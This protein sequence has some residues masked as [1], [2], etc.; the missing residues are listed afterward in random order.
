MTKHTTTSKLWIGLSRRRIG[1]VYMLFAF[2]IAQAHDPSTQALLQKAGGLV[3]QG[4]Y[5][6]ASVL[7]TPIFSAPNNSIDELQL[8]EALLLKGRIGLTKVGPIE[9]P[10][11]LF[12]ESL[13][14]Y[15]RYQD[16]A[17]ISK[18]NLQLGVVNYDLKNYQDAITYLKN[19]IGYSR[20][21]DPRI[22]IAHYLLAICYSETHEYDEAEDM[23]DLAQRELGK[24]NK[25]FL[26]QIE[27][28]RA[29]MFINRG[30][31]DLALSHLKKLMRE[32]QEL[33]DREH[34]SPIF[35]FLAEAY[36]KEKNYQMAIK[37]AQKA[38]NMSHGQG[39]E[40]IYYRSS[41]NTLHRAYDA[42]NEG[43][44]AYYYLRELSEIK[45]SV[46][47][48]QTF[49]RVAEMRSE[50]EFERMMEQQ[51]AEQELKD[52]IADKEL[53]RTRMTR[54]YLIGGF[55]LALLIAILFLN[56]KNRLSREKS[57][58]D[59]LLLNILPQ[60]IAQELKDQGTAKARKFEQVSV[61]FTD[62]TE[63]TEASEILTPEELVDEINACFEAFDEI[64]EK[65]KI[66]KIKTIGDA[67]MAAGGLPKASSD[68]IKRTVMAAIEMQEFIEARYIMK[69][70]R[71]EVA[72]RMRAGV[73]TGPVVAGIV[74]VKKFQ[75]DTW[76]DTVNTASRIENKSQIGKVNISQATY[77]FIK[78][79]P[80]FRFE[81]RGKIEAKGK[82]EIEMLFVSLNNKD[83]NK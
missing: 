42:I 48:N 83:A 82:G 46:S 13:S 61:L 44:S 76:G 59:S 77:E 68:S 60:E 45:D 39:S 30:D 25:I 53:E 19:T 62:F 33:I 20:P 6:S 23:F 18:A 26:L 15:T 55:T 66:E 41:L 2:G 24:D 47:N 75:Y 29:K 36:L 34:F 79:D 63:F 64:T 35:A 49:Q 65:F 17:G 3:N 43:D 32:Y 1:I 50:L 37:Y 40:T 31:A 56:Q 57:R 9:R 21:D 71:K 16:S 72:F 67:Y 81:S 8:A 4:S 28:F 7:L 5:D 52:A 51:R 22:G 73:H 27:T 58:S 70:D 69:R 12:L 74:G 11:R 54:N 10:T 14:I 38:K 80:D 78:D